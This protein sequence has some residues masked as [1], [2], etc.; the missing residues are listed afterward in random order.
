MGDLN[1][2]ATYPTSGTLFI[3][4]VKK[5]DKCTKPLHQNL[6]KMAGYKK[7]GLV[8]SNVVSLA[9]QLVRQHYW[10]VFVFM[11]Y[12]ELFNSAP[13]PL[14]F[15]YWIQGEYEAALD[16]YDSEVNMYVD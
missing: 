11:L 12:I 4:Y 6:K 10:Y 5:K 3:T 16:I 14:F 2:C 13:P 8:P 9:L 15:S 1:H 7:R